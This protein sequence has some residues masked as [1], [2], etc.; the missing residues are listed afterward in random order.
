[1]AT[2]HFPK[3]K[4]YWN[5]TIKLF[6]GIP[7]TLIGWGKCYPSAKIQ[8][9]YSAVLVDWTTRTL[10]EGVLPNYKDVLPQPTGSAV[11][12]N[13][14]YYLVIIESINCPFS[15]GST[16][17]WQLLCRGERPR[18]ECA[19]YD[20][21]QSDGEAPVMLELW[22]MW[23]TPSLPLLSGPLRPRVVAPDRALS[24]G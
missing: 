10:V 8:L 22:G 18:N 16:I 7:R 19:G 15:G 5:L 4:H 6:C 14:E 20:I 2:P 9:V 17:H 23:S 24:I 21:K 12:L 1:M 13:Y 3:L 11:K